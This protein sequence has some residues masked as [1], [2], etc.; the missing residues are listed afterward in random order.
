M[1]SASPPQGIA[2][3]SPHFLPWGCRASSRYRRVANTPSTS[4]TPRLPAAPEPRLPPREHGCCVNVGT[5]SAA[6]APPAPGT[7]SP[8]SGTPSPA[9]GLAEPG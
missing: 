3:W 2:V 5:A 7:L 9:L 8:A 6:T 4:G 1:S